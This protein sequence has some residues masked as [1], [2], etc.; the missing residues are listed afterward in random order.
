[1]K[2]THSFWDRTVMN[3][4]RHTIRC[5]RV[6]FPFHRAIS[7]IDQRSDPY[8]TRIRITSADLRPEPLCICDFLLTVTAQEFM[9]LTFSNVTSSIWCL[10]YFSL[11]PTPTMAIT[12]RNDR[13]I[14]TFSL[15]FLIDNEGAFVMVVKKSVRLAKDGPISGV[16]LLSNGG[17]LT[18]SALTITVRNNKHGSTSYSSPEGELRQPVRKLAFGSYPSRMISMV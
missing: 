9:W 5:I 16:C 1:M 14:Y 18:A 2:H 15:A 11:L 3:F 8:P 13:Y 17:F 6:S 10:G 12:K 4:P 7:A